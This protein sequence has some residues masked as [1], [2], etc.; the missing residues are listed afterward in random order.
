M[1]VKGTHS[2]KRIDK[3]IERILKIEKWDDIYSIADAVILS[4]GDNYFDIFSNGMKV[5]SKAISSRYNIYEAECAESYVYF[6]GLEDDIVKNLKEI[7]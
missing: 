5:A 7:K 4:D 3:E 1:V 6:V 2:S